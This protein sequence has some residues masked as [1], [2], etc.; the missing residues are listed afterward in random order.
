MS[1]NMRADLFGIVI[2][3]SLRAIVCY[4]AVHLRAT[5]W[6][7]MRTGPI[8]AS[9]IDQYITHVTDYLISHEILD[10]NMYMRCRRLSM[11]L[12]GYALVDV[13]GRPKRLR[14]KIPLTY[15]LAC[16]LMQLV[17][18]AFQGASNCHRRRGSVCCYCSRTGSLLTSGR[19][20]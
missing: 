1:N 16:R 10:S 14:E 3:E 20:S 9:T 4:F 7:K 13:K 15:A 5:R 8:F 17:D 12:E 18:V 19:V 6:N 11:L 2:R